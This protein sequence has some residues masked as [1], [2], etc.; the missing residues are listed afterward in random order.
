MDVYARYGAL[1]GEIAVK[2][3]AADSLH[4]ASVFVYI[5]SLLVLNMLFFD[6]AFIALSLL[7]AVLQGVVFTSAKK[8]L[9]GLLWG[10]PAIAIVAAVNGI[11]S[12]GGETVLVYLFGSPVSAESVFYGLCS[13]VML[14]AIIIYFTVYNRLLPPEKFLYLFSGILPSFSMVVTMT[15]R[16]IPAL[17]KRFGEI[18]AA[19]RNFKQTENGKRTKKY[20]PLFREISALLS[21]S[22]EEGLETADSMKAK[23]YGCTKRSSYEIYDFTAKDIVLIAITVILT[24]AAITFYY[25]DGK[26]EFYPEIVYRVSFLKYISLAAVFILGLILPIGEAVNCLRWKI[27]EKY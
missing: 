7:L 2:L 1:G 25:L 4:P 18:R 6:P 10:L 9:K 14:I 8:T 15:Q 24:A 23:G 17:I 20:Q 3:K 26:I 11:V 12:R 16:F 13:G 27:R 22:M 5:I 19:R 21:W